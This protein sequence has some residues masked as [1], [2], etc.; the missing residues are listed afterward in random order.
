MRTRLFLVIAALGLMALVRLDPLVR[1]QTPPDAQT[2]VTCVRDVTLPSSSG[3]VGL[4]A[5]VTTDRPAY[6]SGTPVTFT[7]TLTNPT[8]A[9]LTTFAAGMLLPVFSVRTAVG[10]IVWL[11]PP[12]PYPGTFGSCTFAPGAAVTRSIMWNQRRSVGAPPS[13]R[14]AVAPGSYTVRGGLLNESASAA[15]ATFAIQAAEPTPRP[16]CPGGAYC[17]G[18]CPV[19]SRAVSLAQCVPT[20][21]QRVELV[22]GCNNVVSTFPDGS[23]PRTVYYAT[24]NGSIGPGGVR[25]IWRYDP[26]QKRFLGWSSET[27]ESANDLTALQRLDAIY[28]CM[29]QSGVLYRPPA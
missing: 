22:A 13:D 26:A 8:D 27:P 3:I 14:L 5:S 25:A 9:P 21:W 7:L 4:S 18:A 15:E 28:I 6:A 24:T 20:D 16:R 12:T 23:G 1:A 17:P 11:Y 10:E 19:G 2:G 29:T